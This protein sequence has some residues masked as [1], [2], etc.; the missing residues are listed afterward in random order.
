[1]KAAPGRTIGRG[2][3]VNAA[4]TTNAM[5]LAGQGPMP[6]PI[7]LIVT[8]GPLTQGCAGSVCGRSRHVPGRSSVRLGVGR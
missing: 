3:A 8:F 7:C 6:L 4:G 5:H 2:P 1:M